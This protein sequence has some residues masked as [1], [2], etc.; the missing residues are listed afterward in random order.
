MD[1]YTIGIILGAILQPSTIIALILALILKRKRRSIILIIVF[2]ICILQWIVLRGGNLGIGS[3][4]VPIISGF[5]V[6]YIVSIFK[7]NKNEESP[8]KVVEET[9]EKPV[10]KKKGR[11]PRFIAYPIYLFIFVIA[12]YMFTP[13]QDA[14][15]NEIKPLIEGYSTAD[16]DPL[17]HNGEVISQDLMMYVHYFTEINTDEDFIPYVDSETLNDYYYVCIEDKNIFDIGCMANKKQPF[18]TDDKCAW[19]F[20]GYTPIAKYKNY[21]LVNIEEKACGSMIA[22]FNSYYLLNYDGHQLIVDKVITAGRFPERPIKFYKVN[23][24][25]FKFVTSGCYHGADTC[26]GQRANWLEF[27]FND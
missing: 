6:V 4:I 19:T 12:F 20:F 17:M 5:L 23:D 1:A 24:S 11:L 21:Y 7:S 16:Y 13:L 14:Y 10:K 27:T 22:R 3:L 2:V 8:K 9:K 25:G 15:H 18:L 26:R